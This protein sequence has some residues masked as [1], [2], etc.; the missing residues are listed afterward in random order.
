MARPPSRMVCSSLL[1]RR[2]RSL[3]AVVTASAA[4]LAALH[5]DVQVTLADQQQDPNS[6]L[7]S[8]K[9]SRA[10]YTGGPTLSIRVDL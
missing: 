10:S 2:P 1:V 3:K 4:L 5:A 6:P 7:Y 8:A 9:V